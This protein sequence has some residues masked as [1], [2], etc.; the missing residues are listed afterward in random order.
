[1]LPR[2]RWVVVLCTAMAPLFVQAQN[3]LAIAGGIFDDRAALAVR[4][5]FVP[6]ANVT[7]KLYRDGESAAMASA[8]TNAGG[9]YVFR[10]LGAGAYWVAV[11]SKT[12]GPAGTWA[13][14]TFGPAGSL[15]AS[16][17]GT[18]RAIWFEGACFSGRSAN[19][20]DDASALATSEHVARVD[21]R[22]P[23]TS[24]DFAFSFDAVTTTADG[25]R[26]Q[27]S[28]RQ[29]LTNANAL[30][31]PNRMR[32][33]PLERAREQRET[34]S[35]VPPR[36]WSIVLGSALPELRDADTWIDGTAY[37]F[38]SPAT[39]ANV[40]PGRYGET[41]TLQENERL[42][43]RLEKPELEL[44][45]TGSDG[46]VC[47]ARCAVSF[48]AL[49]GAPN[50]MVTRADARLE[51]VVIGAAPDFSPA[52]AFGTTGLQV[53]S[54]TTVARQVLVTGQTRAGIIV[55]R[56]AHFDGEHLDVS[57]CGDPSTGGAIVLFSDG[58]SVRSSI[59][60]ANGG[61]G[62]IIGS[63]DG[64]SPA[65]ANT[66]DGS[67]ISGNQAGVI[68]GPGSSRNVITRNEIMWNRLGG[69][70]S[71]PFETAA[72]APRENRFSANRFNENGLRPIV[73]NVGVDNPNELSRGDAN[74]QRASGAANG[75]ISA[76]HLTEVRVVEEGT[77]A[78]VVLRGR[79]CPGEIVELYQSYVTTGVRN[80]EDT[81][82]P[83][84]RN[85]RTE[86]GR[87]TI[88]NDEREMALPSIGEFNYLGATNTRPD[89]TFE[90]A[91][92]LPM[93]APVPEDTRNIEET[94]IWARQVLPGATPSDRA[95]SALS[96][97]PAGNTSEM[98]VRRVVD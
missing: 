16:P 61:G 91:F 83:Q 92:P 90:A 18:A 73:L 12:V 42:T 68:L 43:P 56:N 51:H 93:L 32:F 82:L 6:V 33:V 88:T 5:N 87:E 13:E 40:N 89:G 70:T 35:G 29:F 23:S 66:I 7:V 1:M 9:I 14:Q 69:V 36:W 60:A 26:I 79:S 28:L 25:D 50:T 34:I 63:P 48:I 39:V 76:P 15:C 95:F 67:T 97:D 37:N 62:I 22:E 17:D 85:E 57:R 65:H 78:R 81:E 53:E 77:A 19:V 54:G 75:G 94:N 44:T 58:S 24:V 30:G 46:L 47:A 38:V 72:A 21:L 49:H 86:A 27:G 45:L 80:R 4:S 8:K 10:N 84:I 64:S 55:A 96:I 41:V 98:S 59:I 2:F 74:C 11:D 52:A 20:S 3:A 71:T 31:G